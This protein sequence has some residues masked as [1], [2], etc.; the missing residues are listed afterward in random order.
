MNRMTQLDGLRGI[1]VGLV[2]L[3]HW[4]AA[5]PSLDLG[6]IGVQ[7]FFVLSGFLITG[8]LLDLRDA[9]EAGERRLGAVLATFWQSRAA[10]IWPVCFLTL[11]VVFVAGD[12]F[13]KRDDMA[14]HAFFASNFLFMRRGEYG[15]SLAHFWTLAVEQQFYLVWPIAILLARR[16]W[17]ESIMVALVAL[18]P[19]SRIAVY[20]AGYHDFV[21]YNLLPVASFDS[22]GLGALVALWNRMPEAR[23]APRRRIL[24]IGA[25]VAA[26]CFAVDEAL[27]PLPA[28]VRQTFYAIVF[29]WLVATASDG[30]LGFA[31]KILAARVLVGL[32]VISYAVYVYHMFAP[33]IASAG[34]R[35]V[36][37]PAEFRE[38]AWLFAFSAAVTLAAASLSWFLMERP[39]NRARRRWQERKRLATA[40]AAT[41]GYA[42]PATAPME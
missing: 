20:L 11:A 5:G 1:A 27:G 15:S 39:I 8:I 23:S 12:R 25:M 40:K 38:G 19:V 17:L 13:E 34:L 16:R 10:R 18:A 3:H 36:N 30:M 29:A 31:G 2:V 7:L 37:A 6:N 14:W 32:G 24:S 9:R 42:Q 26:M 21:H 33:R 41:E 35:A 28:N 22:L 4:T